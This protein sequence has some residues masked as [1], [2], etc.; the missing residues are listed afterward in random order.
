MLSGTTLGSTI[1]T[2]SLT[3]VGTLSALTVSGTNVSGISFTKTGYHTSNSAV[4][5]Y[6]NNAG[7]TNGLSVSAP[8]TLVLNAQHDLNGPSFENV[9]RFEN[10]A[11]DI[12]QIGIDNSKIFFFSAVRGTRN[13]SVTSAGAVADCTIDCGTYT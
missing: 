11:S 3:S 5:I 9:I 10:A 7:S 12:G 4:T 1:T 8:P 2:S 6:N 13:F